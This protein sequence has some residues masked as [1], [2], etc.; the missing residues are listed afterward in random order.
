MAFVGDARRYSSSTNKTDV[1]DATVATGGK[2]CVHCINT[3][4][5]QTFTQPNAGVLEVVAGGP[6]EIISSGGGGSVVNGGLVGLKSQAF[7]CKSP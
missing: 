1:I 6:G 7:S 4:S 2:T 5:S 3:P